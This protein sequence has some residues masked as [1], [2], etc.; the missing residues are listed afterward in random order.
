MDFRQHFDTYIN[1]AL[2]GVPRFDSTRV[3]DGGRAIRILRKLPVTSEGKTFEVRTR[4][5]NVW[6]KGKGKGSTVDLSHHLWEVASKESD[7][8]LEY[9]VMEETAYYIGQGGWG[10]PRGEHQNCTSYEN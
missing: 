5:L 3:V 10:G 1:A 8:D 4:V 7:K 6:D 9:F 2:P